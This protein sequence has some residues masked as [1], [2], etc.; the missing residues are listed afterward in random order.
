MKKYIP[1]PFLSLLDKYIM[2]DINLCGSMQVKGLFGTV[3]IMRPIRG[4]I[5]TKRRY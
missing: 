5:K 2:H 1:M 4:K 3:S